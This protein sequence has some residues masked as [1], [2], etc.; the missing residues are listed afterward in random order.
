MKQLN[1]TVC[2]TVKDPYTEG[3]S[4]HE[5][6]PLISRQLINPV[7]GHVLTPRVQSFVSSTPRITMQLRPHLSRSWNAQAESIHCPPFNVHQLLTQ[8]STIMF[9]LVFQ[10]R[11]LLLIG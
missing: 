9:S 1:F 2:S 5:K 7:T 10:C 11:K 4:H 8:H 6:T 3:L